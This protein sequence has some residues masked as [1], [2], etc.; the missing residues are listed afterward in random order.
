MCSVYK[1]GYDS[2]ARHKAE[3]SDTFLQSPLTTELMGYMSLPAEIRPSSAKLTTTKQGWPQPSSPD[4]NSESDMELAPSPTPP[5]RPR[6]RPHVKANQDANIAQGNPSTTRESS[7]GRPASKPRAIPASSDTRSESISEEP[8]SSNST[9]PTGPSTCPETPG[10]QSNDNEQRSSPRPT[11][12][13]TPRGTHDMLREILRTA[14]SPRDKKGV[15]YIVRDPQNP[16]AG[17]KIGKTTRCVMHRIKEHQECCNF[18]PDVIH[19]STT[20]IFRTT[21]AWKGSSSRTWHTRAS[22]GQGHREWFVVSRETALATVQQWERFMQHETPYS[23]TGNLSIVWSYVLEQRSPHPHSLATQHLS[24][25]CRREHWAAILA[26]PTFGEWW[27]AYWAYASML[28]RV[29][30]NCAA[31]ICAYCRGA[32][33]SVHA[34]SVPD[35][36][37]ARGV[38]PCPGMC[39][40]D[41]SGESAAA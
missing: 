25:Q 19:V 1:L 35:A 24:H 2:I 23:W 14:L 9:M 38:Y 27:N 6:R 29:T 41:G 20:D 16:S 36:R 28:L 40:C 3:V 34:V 39:I 15:I 26:P 22:R 8:A 30:R 17:Y 31:K 21:G 32:V 7:N 4:T 10:F 5:N 13:E 11:L 18:T 37:S 12:S 33:W